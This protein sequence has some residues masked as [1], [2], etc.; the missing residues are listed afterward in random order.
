M[1]ILSLSETQAGRHSG[2]K[3]VAGGSPSEY[4]DFFEAI[5]H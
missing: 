3:I 5:D 2:I 1:F 4:F